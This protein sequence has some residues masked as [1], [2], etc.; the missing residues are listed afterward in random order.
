MRSARFAVIALV[1][2]GCAPSARDARAV[3]RPVCAHDGAPTVQLAV[4]VSAAEYPQLRVRITH[5]L[6]HDSLVEMMAARDDGTSAAEWCDAAGCRVIRSAIPTTV[7]LGE[8]RADSS[9][10]VHLSASHPDG[11]RFTWSGV[12]KWHSADVSACG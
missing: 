10:S 2:A 3:L 12:A 11:S 8:Q 9:R 4:P 7:G 6:P 5:A 1:L